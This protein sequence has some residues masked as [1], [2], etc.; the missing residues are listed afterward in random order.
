[1]RNYI[2]NS[3]DLNYLSSAENINEVSCPSNFDI[4][5]SSI[6]CVN[7]NQFTFMVSNSLCGGEVIYNWNFGDGTTATG[8]TVTKTFA[9][10]G[11]YV[12]KLTLSNTSGC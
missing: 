11:T 2:L 8:Q 5:S 3:G 6:S 9:N 7:N 1:M 10:P 12:I 4:K